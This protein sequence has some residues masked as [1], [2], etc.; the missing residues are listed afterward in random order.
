MG[1]AQGTFTA[2]G[3]VALISSRHHSHRNCRICASGLSNK[4]CIASQRGSRAVQVE[5]RSRKKVY[6]S[7]HAHVHARQLA[8]GVMRSVFLAD[9]QLFPR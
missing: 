1:E 6:D 9:I 8:R 5:E 3:L 2:G 4:C 7:S